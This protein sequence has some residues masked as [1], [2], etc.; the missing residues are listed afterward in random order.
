[1]LIENKLNLKKML[2]FNID[3]Q[4]QK[5]RVY[6]KERKERLANRRSYKNIAITRGDILAVVF[7]KQSIIYKF[8]GI[9]LSLKHKGLSNINSSLLL[10]NIYFGI[11]LEC[12]VAY[13]YNRSFRLRILDYKR[14]QF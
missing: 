6:I 9:C 13:F 1:M 11:G 14:K 2:Y 7:R 12:T 8:E 3:E 10:R 5:H 4:V